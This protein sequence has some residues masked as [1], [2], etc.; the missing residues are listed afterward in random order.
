VDEE[1]GYRATIDRDTA[2]P[3]EGAFSARVEVQAAPGEDWRINLFT[4]GVRLEKGRRYDVT[5]L[6]R[7]DRPRNITLGAQK[8]SPDWDGYGLWQAVTLSTEWKEYTVAFESTG[9]DPDARLEFLFGERAGTV[10]IDA[11]RMGPHPAD[12]FQREFDNGL[13]ILNA[14]REGRTI[15]LDRAWRKL[16]GAQAPLW[17]V[18]VDDGDPSFS[19][20]GLVLSTPL[21][22]GEWKAA[23][24]FYH[25]WGGSLHLLPPGAAAEWKWSVP[26]DD[27]YSIDAW[28]PAAPAAGIW[29]TAARYEVWIGGVRLATAAL[30][31]TRTGDEWHRIADLRLPAGKTA[32]IRLV[33]AGTR[34]CA[35]D[36]LFIHSAAR[37]NDG[38]LIQNIFLPAMDAIILRRP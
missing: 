7:A 1:N 24:P 32:V 22:S 31:Q 38:S 13:V 21:D 25:S 30:D 10:W 34:P 17:E 12:V 23:G 4:D 36:A 2:L 26:A 11:V 28:W 8:G 6:A 20:T 35:A 19:T 9:T 16:T 3:G 5:F 37:W 29:N 14:S 33:C 27:E 18:L 15:P